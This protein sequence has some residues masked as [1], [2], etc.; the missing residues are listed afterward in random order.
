MYGKYLLD[1]EDLAKEN[2]YEA[3][4]NAGLMAACRDAGGGTLKTIPYQPKRICFSSIT[5][6]CLS[7]QESQKNRRHGMNSKM[8]ARN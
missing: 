1:L 8:Y 2:D 6:I 5:K 4:A 7:R 3:T